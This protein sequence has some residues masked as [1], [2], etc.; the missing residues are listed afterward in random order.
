MINIKDLILDVQRK[1]AAVNSSTSI[2]DLENLYKLAK[3]LDGSMSA[4]YDSDGQLPDATSAGTRLAYIRNTGRVRL[5]NG[6]WDTVAPPA[7]VPEVWYFGGTL[8]GYVAGGGGTANHSTIDQFSFTSDGNSANFGN[9]SVGRYSVSGTSSDVSGYGSGG[10]NAN[11]NLDIIDK[12]PFASG[13][14]ATSVGTLGAINR[15]DYT[16]SA[17]QTNGYMAG[18]FNNQSLYLGVIYKIP[19]AADGNAINVG[20]LTTPRGFVAGNSSP[21]YGYITGGETPATSTNTIEKWPFASDTSSSS[22]GTL[23]WYWR[24]NSG[25]SSD[26]YGYVSGGIIGT[27][28]TGVT[29]PFTNLIHKWPFASESTYTSVG[30]LTKQVRLAS[31][32]SSTTYGYTAAGTNPSG[33]NGLNIID[34]F[35]FASDGNA[36]DV[37]DLTIA[38]GYRAG[39][40]H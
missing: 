26:T 8:N 4:V 33:S 21:T 15:A 34:K 39:M 2:N 20:N 7:V 31:S 12:F 3:V 30:T 35:P 14:T 1:I 27:T 36:T 23:G 16:G 19:F 9:L 28:A 5:N 37:G 29:E 10:V 32:P 38:A 18:G 24:H 6:K 17:S 13:G 25:N 11:G 40:Q 22:A